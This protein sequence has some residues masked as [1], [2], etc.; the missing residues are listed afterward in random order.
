MA[1]ASRVLVLLDDGGG[2]G[3]RLVTLR[4][5]GFCRCLH[6]AATGMGVL[7]TET[8]DAVRGGSVDGSNDARVPLLVQLAWSGELLNRAPAW[9]GNWLR[10]ARGGRWISELHCSYPAG[11][12]AG[13]DAE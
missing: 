9:G 5:P 1:A 3:H 4:A 2:A 6:G 11:Y 8:G 13:L 10:R 7:A 12:P